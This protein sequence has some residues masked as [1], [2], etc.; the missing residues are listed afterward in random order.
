MPF[1]LILQITNIT[2]VPE[3][4]GKGEEEG[5]AFIS[6]VLFPRYMAQPGKCNCHTNITGKGNTIDTKCGSVLPLLLLFHPDKAML[7]V[8]NKV[9]L[10]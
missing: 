4:E 9:R 10:R 7:V 8:H 2:T 6:K 3:G 1:L 5:S